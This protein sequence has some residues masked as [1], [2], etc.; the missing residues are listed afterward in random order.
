MLLFPN[1]LLVFV[2]AVCTTESFLLYSLCSVPNKKT[3]KC[4]GKK[5]ES[6]KFSQNL[7]LSI[8][9]VVLL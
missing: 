8:R 7:A 3:K 4:D 5:I 6:T 1:L 2:F 9:I